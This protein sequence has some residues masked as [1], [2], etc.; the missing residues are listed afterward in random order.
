VTRLRV[1]YNKRGRVRF[2]SHRDVARCLERAVRRAGLP[3]A[4]SQGFSPRARL[5]FGLAL[6]NGFESDA[7]FFDVD[8][9]DPGPADP[10]SADP[11]DLRSTMER[12][13]AGHLVGAGG[14]A[15]RLSSVLP[16]GID[17][18]AVV[19]IAAGTASLQDS[20]EVCTW[21]F[22]LVEVPA[23]ALD[24]A[25]T[26]L[27]DRDRVEVTLIRKGKQVSED[28]RPLL[29]EHSTRMSSEGAVLTI[30]L[31]TKPRSV[32]P[33]EFLAALDAPELIGNVADVRV[34]RT[35]QWINLDGQRC[36]PISLP[37]PSTH[38]EE[39]AS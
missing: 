30:D 14:L 21:Q 9:V 2:L 33:V 26:R 13:V 16:D 28:L 36:E 11:V 22:R 35:H 7:E 29:G 17:V 27:L 1:R 31:G 18:A 19:P 39:R 5:H 3:V 34:L 25:A 10:G 32:R 15:E 24:A 23:D 38:A 12:A 37:R 20:V 6:S 8:L 4:Y